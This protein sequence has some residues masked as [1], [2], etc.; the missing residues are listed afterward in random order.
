M[1]PSSELSNVQVVGTLECMANR[2]AV[3]EAWEALDP[4]QSFEVLSP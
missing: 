3:Q 4:Q 2:S 1:N